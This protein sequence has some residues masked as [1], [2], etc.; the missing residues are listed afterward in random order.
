[1]SKRE[2]LDEDWGETTPNVIPEEEKAE[3]RWAV[4]VGLHSGWITLKPQE[5][6]VSYR[7][8]YKAIRSPED[9]FEL[10]KKSV[11]SAKKAI[12]ELKDAG[13]KGQR[14]TNARIR[15]SL[16]EGRLSKARGAMGMEM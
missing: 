3:Y 1:M 13:V 16:S 2:E 7:Q 15:L 11:N 14:L 6:I 12:K 4:Q 10:Q 8:K 9:D 5:P